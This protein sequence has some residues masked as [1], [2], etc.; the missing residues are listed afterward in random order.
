MAK[1]QVMIDIIIDDKGTT[2]RVAVDAGKLGIQLDKAAKASEKGAKNTDKLSKSTKDLDRNMRGTAKMSGNQ[3]KE[4]SKMQQGMGGLVGAYATLAAQV[5]AVSAAFQFLQGASNMRNLINGQEALGAMTGT[6]YKTITNSIIEAT[7][8]QIKYSDAAKAAAI[9]SAAGLT[10]GQLTRLGEVAKNASFALGRDLTDSFNRLVRGVTKAEP[11]LL[12]ELGIIL[13]LD[14]ATRK[15]AESIGESAGSLTAFQ[16]SQAVANEVLEQ[17]EQKFAAINHMMS[18]DAANLAQFTKSF[19]DLFNT[20]KI[21]VIEGLNPVLKFLSGNTMALVAAIGLFAIPIVKSILPNLNDWRETQGKVFEEHKQN[22]SIYKQ[23]IMDQASAIKQLAGNQEA[24]GKEASKAAERTGKDA[25]KGG[26]GYVSGGKDS[27]QARIAAK[28]GLKQAENDLKKHGVVMN[29]IFKGY[30]AKEVAIARASYNQRSGMAKTHTN[31]VVVAFKTMGARLQVVNN[32]IK[33]GWAK[34]MMTMTGLA[35]AASKGINLIMS[36]MGIIGILSMI[37]AAAIAAYKYFNPMT[38]EAKRA[39]E[40]VENLT[41][42]YKDLGEEM[43]LSGEARAKYS[44]G[45]Q[46][47]VNIGNMMQSADV[48]GIIKDLNAMAAMTDKSSSE[49]ED[50]KAKL[51]PV[52]KELVKV[53]GGFQGL[54]DSLKNS[55]RIEEDQAKTLKGLADGFAEVG[56]IISQLPD[57]IQKANQAFTKL[58]DSMTTANPMDSFLAEEKLVLSGLETKKKAAKEMKLQRA[59]EYVDYEDTVKSQEEL[60]DEMFSKSNLRGNLLAQQKKK[61]NKIVATHG[62]TSQQAADYR[63]GAE[64]AG[65]G[66]TNFTNIR[67]ETVDPVARAKEK[68]E[69]L[70]LRNLSRDEEENTDDVLTDRTKRFERFLSLR[71]TQVKRAKEGL[72]VDTKALGNTVVAVTLAGKLNNLQQKELMT[73]KGVVKAE[74]K[75]AIATLR[76]TILQEDLTSGTNKYTKEQRAA[77]DEAVEFQTQQVI[78]QKAIAALATLTNAQKQEQVRLEMKLLGLQIA[79]MDAALKGKGTAL[80]I[81]LNSATGGGTLAANRENRRLVGIQLADKIK[82]EENKAELAAI[83]YNKIYAEKLKQNYELAGGTDENPLSGSAMEG[84]I[85]KSIA[86]TRKD[87][88]DGLNNANAGVTA[89]LQAQTIH[90]SLVQTFVNQTTAKRQQAAIDLEALGY[91]KEHAG[92]MAEVLR[93]KSLGLTVSEQQIELLKQEATETSRLKR[94]S[95]N[96]V[97]IREG[98]TQGFAGAFESIIDGSK[99]AKEDFQDMGKSMLAML[100]KIIAQELAL[101]AVKAIGNTFGIGF[102]MADGGITPEFAKGGYTSPKRSYG[103]GGTARGPKSGY[104]AVLHGNEAVVPLPDNRN[105]P[106]ELSGNTGGQSNVTVNVAMDSSGNASQTSQQDSAQ[107]GKLGNMIASAVQQELQFQKRS[108]G[109]LNPYGVA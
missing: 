22:S 29:G 26:V 79:Q 85:A 39:A 9:G 30:T 15:Y 56:Q 107:M 66:I 108:G 47:A 20:I 63:S 93:M 98:L 41:N 49:F 60:D 50:L 8:A 72:I 24:L 55:S 4:F 100:A 34:T 94:M 43:R 2:K 62:R 52:T 84:V 18:A 86:E 87:T 5:F 64:G 99:S 91:G 58:F 38:E 35:V 81:G 83:T 1:N 74:D 70:R 103:R 23:N 88:G 28:K 89:A 92:V 12:D 31:T 76:K 57:V 71:T 37:V 51:E 33:I 61:F 53:D 21:T 106:V 16:R 42:K 27:A 48:K 102:L 59:L 17:G 65:H 109:I 80:A 105:I 6:A 44:T 69:I 90:N 45:S 25:T 13:R 11:E 68:A 36:A 3:T 95:D 32:T 75:L 46:G 73:K 19:D 67:G 78:N 101:A 97:T 40:Q 96:L 54:A 77:A 10:S 7:D 104:N 82:S 14:T